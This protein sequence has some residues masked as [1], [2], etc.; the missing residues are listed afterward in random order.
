MKSG[1][2]R[3]NPYPD[4]RVIYGQVGII[5]DIKTSEDDIIA[6]TVKWEN[7]EEQEIRKEESTENNLTI[8]DL[9]DVTP[10]LYVNVYLWDQA[11]GGPEEGGWW[12]STYDPEESI[13]CASVE[14]AERILEEKRA[15]CEEENLTRRHPS[16]VLSDGHYV[17]E[18]D[19]WPA[20]RRPQYTPRYC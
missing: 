16:S 9:E 5:T 10:K 20:E 13:K 17:V 7:G 15:W 4:D 3:Y 12:Y 11:Y 14:E 6:I 19:A 18:L 2:E 8:E 1:R